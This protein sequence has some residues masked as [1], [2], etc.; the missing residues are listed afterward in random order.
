[1]PHRNDGHQCED[2]AVVLEER[3]GLLQGHA[4]AHD[5]LND[6]AQ[7]AED[8]QEWQPVGSE[9]LAGGVPRGA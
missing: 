9:G 6:R 8:R 4:C 3:P 2:L 5:L 1:M 7:K